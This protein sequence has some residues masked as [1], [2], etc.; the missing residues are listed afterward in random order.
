MAQMFLSLFRKKSATEDVQVA[1]AKET[2]LAAPVYG[3]GVSPFVG[4]LTNIA[5][6]ID[7]N[8]T[9][10]TESNLGLFLSLPE[11]FFPIDFIASRIAGAHYE[12]KRVSDDSIVWC[13]GRSYKAQKIAKILS[14]PN[15][16]Q[17]FSEFMYMRTVNTLATGNG[18]IKAAMAES[19][20]PDKPK[21]RWCDNFWSVPT[22]LVGIETNGACI[23]LYGIGTLDDMIKGY[24]IGNDIRLTPA[25]QV[26]HE[27]DTYPNFGL[28]SGNFLMSASRL[29]A[30]RRTIATLINVYK[31]RNVI[32]DRCG[33]I[34]VLTNKAKDDT[35]HVALTERE[36][37]QLYEQYF[38][39]H[40]I[41]DGKSP[42]LITDA[43]VAYFRIGMSISELKPFEETLL[44]AITIAGQFGIPADLV[45]RKD[46]ST[47]DNKASAEKGVYSGVIIPMAKRFCQEFTE[48]LGIEGD[49]FYIDCNFD[50]VDCLQIGR[51]EAETV[52]TM[53]N[54]R[55]RQQFLDGL[56]TVNDWRGQIHEAALEGDVFNKTRFE[57]TDDELAFVARVIENKT[58]NTN[59]QQENGTD[60]EKPASA[61]ESK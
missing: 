47:Y 34:G 38:K 41:T 29:D 33:A 13:T 18:F 23:P 24:R 7:M 52:K 48:F 20:G 30:L 45:P 16:L 17:T 26:W 57:M 4:V 27:R 56:I 8:P 53:V 10:L 6:A 21:W 40:G 37:D 11:V 5:R 46:N 61:D 39:R 36:K 3:H 35:G 14:R 25:W 44:D 32:Y 42:L 28:S 19:V 31:A 22:P 59:P 58:I 15:P 55:C 2:G 60:N 49:G 51:K 12:I 54:T 1:G 9:G 50:D 43:D